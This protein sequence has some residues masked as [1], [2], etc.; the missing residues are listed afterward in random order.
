MMN[1]NRFVSGIGSLILGM[2]LFLT[3]AH[4]IE[5]IDF[6]CDVYLEYEETQG[7]TIRTNISVYSDE[8]M[9]V[10]GS[11]VEIVAFEDDILLAKTTLDTGV[12]VFIGI[13]SKTLEIYVAVIRNN[14]PHQI[15]GGQCKKM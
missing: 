6:Q 7:K 5:R 4:A 3:P 9:T 15:G 12:V 14:E 1:V 11:Q 13:H 8:R 10:D 2:L